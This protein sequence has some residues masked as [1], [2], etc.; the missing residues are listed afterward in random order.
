[1]PH[2]SLTL[3]G[4][5]STLCLPLGCAEAPVEPNVFPDLS[6]TDPD[7][8]TY[9]GDIAP[10]LADACGNCHA[11]DA[12]APMTFDTYESAVQW[13]PVIRASVDS[14]LMP[15]FNANNDGSCNTYEDA[16]WLGDEEIAMIDAWIDQ[17]MPEGDPA[18]G[19]PTPPALPQLRGEHLMT[20]AGPVDYHPVSEGL[21]VAKADDYQCFLVDPKLDRDQ[22]LVGFDVLAGNATTV[23][24]VVGF[25]VDLD[26]DVIV[27]GQGLT[28]NR[29]LIQK[30]DDASPDAP[31]WDCFAAAGEGVM[32]EGVPVTWAPGTGAT[33]FPAGTGIRIAKQE[34]LVLQV[35]YNLSAHDGAPDSTHVTLDLVD[36]VERE[37]KMALAD[38]FLT[39]LLDP[40][41]AR[42]PVGLPDATFEWSMAL[43]AIPTQDLSDFGEIEVLGVLPHMHERG[44]TMRVEFD[45]A[46]AE[47]ACGAQVDHWDFGWQQV[48][49]METPVRMHIS[50]QMRVRCTYDTRDADAPVGPGFGT[51][52]E[53]CLAG[54]YIV[55]AA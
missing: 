46:D 44:R 17:G 53:M 22:F 28:T 51:G 54:I 19:V 27:G 5:V 39:T 18:L 43:D 35:H 42:L 41:P 21:A 11:P 40:E 47:P 33:V 32:I 1:M 2:R 31:G 38:G 29:A 8:L 20:L 7:A 25:N 34:V 26:R 48:F 55:P 36:E 6:T 52:D 10:L 3:V 12:I 13:A 9:Y 15:P 4:L 37:A 30:L 50:D 16:R 45:T 24:H 49:F 14:R 23:H